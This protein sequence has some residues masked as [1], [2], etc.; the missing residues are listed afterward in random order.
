MEPAETPKPPPALP[1]VEPGAPPIVL[2]ATVVG[3]PPVITLET[4]R[5]A[6]DTEAPQAVPSDTPDPAAPIEAAPAPPPAV[7]PPSP[8]PA[9]WEEKEAGEWCPEELRLHLPKFAKFDYRDNYS[10]SD[11]AP[12][13]WRIVA[14]TRRGRLHAHHGTHRED[15][16]HFTKGER[17]TV[18][19]VSDG[20]GSCRYSR[21]GSET[22]SRE[23]TRRLHEWLETNRPTLASLPAGELAKLI[24]AAMV[25]AV[26]KTVLGLHELATKAACSPKDFRCT[27]LLAVL[28]KSDIEAAL[29]TSQVGDGFI[30]SLESDGQAQR[31]GESDSGAYSGEVTCFIPDA[32]SPTHASR[33]R[34]LPVGELESLILC[35]D[36]IEDPFYPL[37]KNAAVI[38]HQ[39]YH[40][41]TD[42]LSGFENQA[43]FAPVIG[44]PA[45][46]ANLEKWLGFEK[47]GENDDRTIVVLHRISPSATMK[48][49]R[50]KT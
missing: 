40:G 38:F 48:S 19:C 1:V 45:A 41:A 16:F 29:L 8:K 32:D 26:H 7:A 5:S 36:G 49:I 3:A 25:D 43:L 4:T 44:H 31:H 14:A 18:L 50:P 11:D 6:I 35:S 21:I 46:A 24:G 12:G 37:E 42:K 2:D 10:E 28:Y 47:K 22:T 13:G 27:L 39:L 33:I 17:F 20:A 15:A 23:I 34:L 9:K 30:A